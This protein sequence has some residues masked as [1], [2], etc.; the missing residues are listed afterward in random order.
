MHMLIS[1]N[2]LKALQNFATIN[3]N[4]VVTEGSSTIRTVSEAKNI[5]ARA[6]TED[7]F[8]AGF[9]IFDLNEFL[10]AVNIIS[11]PEFEFNWDSI[12]IKSTNSKSSIKYFCANPS[13]LTSP[14]SD[15]TDPAYEIAIDLTQAN[16]AAIKRASTVLG[17]DRFSFVKDA[18]SPSVSVQVADVNN[19]SSN[20]YREVVGEVDTSEEFQFDFLIANLKM[21]PGDYKVEL[22]SKFIS[23]WSPASSNTPKIAYWL[24]IETTGKYNA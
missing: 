12:T 20:V 5:M 10:S 23:R 14:T 22:S 6:E 21:V 17:H 24:A 11:A 1:T 15:I 8:N 9:G 18:D 16:I 3:P 2:T 13:I 4:I 7:T 19:K